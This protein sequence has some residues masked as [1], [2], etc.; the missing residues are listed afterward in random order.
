MTIYSKLMSTNQVAERIQSH[1][2]SFPPPIPFARSKRA[3]IK[4]EPTDFRE[5]E[6]LF[7]PTDE[8][9]QKTKKAVLTY[10]DGDAEMWCEW[11]EQLDE[12]YCLV[13][14]TSTEQQAKA[15]VSLL[16]GKALALYL[17]HQSRIEREQP[18]LQAQLL[19][20]GLLTSQEILAR[21]LD[22]LAK[23]FFPV[24]HAYR[25]Q[26][27][28]MR[29]HL[30][31][32]GKVTVREFDMRLNRMSDYLQYFP[33]IETA[34]G[35]LNQCQVL[36][37]DQLCDI[38]NLAKKPEWTLKMMEANVDPYDL[39][40]HDLLDYLERLELV[41]SL[42]QK[43]K[44]ENQRENQRERQQEHPVFN[45]YK[46]DESTSSERKPKKPR[47][48]C[49]ICSKYHPVQCCFKDNNNKEGNS[50]GQKNHNIGLTG[51][52]LTRGVYVCI[53]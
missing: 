24:K 12:L 14:L 8:N 44:Q 27:F 17:T 9:S 43:S 21:S 29:Y 36:G 10:E 1:V 39:D 53:D 26:I 30:F 48:Q 33:T 16:R 4:H 25:R 52:R 50:H 15:I 3:S 42:L 7:D 23:E 40:L 41:N 28:Y 38:I 6:M 20:Q 32:G 19:T 2:S 5:F 49:P 46:P 37:D 22:Q 18:A 31:I 34:T 13:P 11:R 51:Y 45:K 35:N 47:T